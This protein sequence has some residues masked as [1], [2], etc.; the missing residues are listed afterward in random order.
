MQLG[1]VIKY[2]EMTNNKPNSIIHF[3]RKSHKLFEMY[4]EG[5]ID[6]INLNIRMTK[7][8][9]ECE[10]MYKT[11]MQQVYHNASNFAIYKE[12]NNDKQ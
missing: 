4:S 3:S 12:V 9:E 8:T 11:E 2:K 5:K 10:A 6:R 1:C 7:L